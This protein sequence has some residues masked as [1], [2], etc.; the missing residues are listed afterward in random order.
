[1]KIT[2]RFNL[3]TH[4]F[5][6]SNIILGGVISWIIKKLLDFAYRKLKK[7]KPWKKGDRFRKWIL[8]LNI[9]LLATLCSVHPVEIKFTMSY[10]AQNFGWFNGFF[11]CFK[12]IFSYVYVHS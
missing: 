8:N 9:H 12:A 4:A 1:M 2:S 5:C 11:K 7:R 3:S 6:I 10:C